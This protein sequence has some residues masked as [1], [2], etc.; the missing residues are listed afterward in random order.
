[1]INFQFMLFICCHINESLSFYQEQRIVGVISKVLLVIY[2][3]ESL[4]QSE[5]INL[6]IHFIRKLE[7]H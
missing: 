1:M 3:D 6:V 4:N 7:R 2:R 5:V